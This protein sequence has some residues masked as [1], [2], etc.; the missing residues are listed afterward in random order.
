MAVDRI[1]AVRC[2]LCGTP[3][4]PAPSLRPDEPRCTTDGPEDRAA[5]AAQQR[6]EAG[7]RLRWL[8]TTVRPATLLEAGPADGYFLEAATT[9]GIPAAGIEISATA[10]RFAREQLGQTVHHG[11]FETLAPHHRAHTVCA[12]H[13]LGHVENPRTFLHAVRTALS[14]GGWLALEVPNTAAAVRPVDGR[15]PTPTDTRDD[16]RWHFTPETL[17]RLLVQTG[18]RVISHDTVFSRFYQQPRARWRHVRKL[19][20][21]D[22]LATGSP[23]LSHPHLGDLLRVFARHDGRALGR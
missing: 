20:V 19:L 1:E 6:F 4:S 22:W 16:H 13:V 21:E 9:A 8:L 7:R 17:T 14:P 3:A 18:F 23:R 5:A 15:W 10:T 12:F 2:R 11:S